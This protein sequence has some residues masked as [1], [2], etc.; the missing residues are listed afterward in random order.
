[1]WMLTPEGDHA[2]QALANAVQVLGYATFTL[3]AAALL[4]GVAW[5]VGGRQR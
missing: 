1:M 5:L 3:T 4:A 2:V